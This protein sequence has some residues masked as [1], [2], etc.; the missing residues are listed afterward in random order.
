MGQCRCEKR[1]SAGRT[2]KRSHGG[3]GVQPRDTDGD[4][5]RVLRAIEKTSKLKE[6]GGGKGG[7]GRKK[8]KP[9]RS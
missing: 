2:K 1:A 5:E 6:K 3:G 9:K 4:H 8:E 7:R